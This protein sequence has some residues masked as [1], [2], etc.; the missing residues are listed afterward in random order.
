MREGETKN[1]VKCG[2]QAAFRRR[3]ERPYSGAEDKNGA[4]DQ[5]TS[6]HEIGPGWQCSNPNCNY[7]EFISN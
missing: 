5:A 2:K 6:P 3:A 4:R 7:V 1:C